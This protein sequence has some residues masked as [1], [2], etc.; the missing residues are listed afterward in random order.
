MYKKYISSIFCNFLSLKMDLFVLTVCR[1]P[2]WIW[3]CVVIH[4]VYK[5]RA[6]RCT[7]IFNC[8]NL[9]RTRRG[10]CPKNCLAI[11]PAV[12]MMTCVTATD[13]PHWGSKQTTEYLWAPM[14]RD[15]EMSKSDTQGCSRK[16]KKKKEEILCSTEKPLSTEWLEIS[17][18]SQ[19]TFVCL[20]GEK[21][22]Y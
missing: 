1:V 2:H 4:A 22:Q 21:S 13:W 10:I 18:T 3:L 8:F 9:W 19:T 7:V 5:L 17:V 14:Q 16:W 20:A 11:L 6:D 15:E 12:C